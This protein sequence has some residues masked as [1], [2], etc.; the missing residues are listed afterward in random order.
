[1]VMSMDWHLVTHMVATMDVV[2][3]A[4]MEQ[5]KGKLKANRMAELK[6]ELTAY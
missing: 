5:R 3:V 6:V 1:M 4:S 2:M